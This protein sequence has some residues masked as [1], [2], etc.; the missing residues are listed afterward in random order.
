LKWTGR[1][2]PDMDS[3]LASSWDSSGGLGSIVAGVFSCE[4]VIKA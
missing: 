1:P 3:S 2:F 4:I